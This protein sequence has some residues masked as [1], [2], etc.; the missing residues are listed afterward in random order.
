MIDL[1]FI[2]DPL[3]NKTPPPSF[4]E[5]LNLPSLVS[6]QF[7]LHLEGNRL[8]PSRSRSLCRSHGALCWSSRCYFL[9]IA[10][11]PDTRRSLH[12]LRLEESFVRQW[13]ALHVPA[14]HPPAGP[15]IPPALPRLL[16][17]RARSAQLRLER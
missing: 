5:P 8:F 14:E 16:V 17:P 6:D 2:C 10:A 12:L 15:S 13:S 11:D 7:L 1:M 9:I 3:G 4:S